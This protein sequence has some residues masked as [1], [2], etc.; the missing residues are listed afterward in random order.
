MERHKCLINETLSRFIFIFQSQKCYLLPQP[1][2]MKEPKRWVNPLTSQKN[3]KL[4]IKAS[5]AFWSSSDCL[6]PFCSPSSFILPFIHHLWRLFNLRTVL[7]IKTAKTK[8]LPLLCGLSFIK[9]LYILHLLFPA[10]AFFLKSQICDR[11]KSQFVWCVLRI[12][13]L[14]VSVF[15][16]GRPDSGCH[17]CDGPGWQ[18]QGGSIGNATWPTKIKT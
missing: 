4:L 16:S 3:N 6:P 1:T 11:G 14:P 10:Q 5:R 2:N 9:L 7:V 13:L 17:I 12:T 18:G 15:A 8:H